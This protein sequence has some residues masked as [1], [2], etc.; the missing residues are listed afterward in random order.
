M[1]YSRVSVWS[2]VFF[3]L[4][5]I[6]VGLPSMGNHAS[7]SPAGKRPQERQKPPAHLYRSS[8]PKPYAINVLN[9]PMQDV[10]ETY[11][12][13]PELGRGQF[14]VTRACTHKATGERLACKSISKR[15]ITC[16][17]DV[18]DVRREIRVLRQLT[19]HPNIVELRGV[20]EDRQAVHLVLELCAGGELFERII[21]KGKYSEREAAA[22]FRT[23]AE[24]LQ[25]CHSQG[26]MHRDLKPEN[27]LLFSKEE[28]SPL[29]AIDF[30]LSAFFKPGE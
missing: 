7:A 25:T 26:I 20:Y 8:V 15:K 2:R 11:T 4:H 1:S 23:I 22:A 5:L 17:E 30:G 9:K 18:D 29:K 6:P 19:G 28:D 13:G 12:L 16:K 21:S 24:V 10:R 14:G 3:K 27:F